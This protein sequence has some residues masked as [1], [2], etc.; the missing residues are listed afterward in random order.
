MLRLLSRASALALVSCTVLPNEPPPS[1]LQARADA[2][3]ARVSRIR[4][5]EQRRSVPAARQSKAELHEVFDVEIEEE[6]RE[7]GAGMERA[8]KAFGLMPSDLDLKPFLGEFLRESVGGYYDPEEERFFVIADDAD[9]TSDGRDDFDDGE[10]GLD[11][12]DAAEEFVLAHEL[13]HAID[14]Q[15]FDF[16]RIEEEREFDDDRALAFSSLVEGS[17][18][19]GGVEYVL[20]RG[21]L[22]MSSAGPFLSPLIGLFSGLSPA[23]ID[24]LTSDLDDDQAAVMRRAPPILKYSLTFPYFQGWAF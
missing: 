5:L 16:D 1:D 18:M 21:G 22:P 7:G 24:D 20:D 4:D 15:A 14:D 3:A 11:E 2:V 10:P 17:A 12:D 13:T 9:G 23:R 6:W 19:E 8:M